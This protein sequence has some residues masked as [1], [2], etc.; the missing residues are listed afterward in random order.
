MGSAFVGEEGDEE[1]AD[2]EYVWVVGPIHGTS[3]FIRICVLQ[4][5]FMIKIMH[6]YILREMDES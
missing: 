2:A 5:G 1:F 6:H 3:N 4:W